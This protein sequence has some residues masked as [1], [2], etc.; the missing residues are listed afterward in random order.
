MSKTIDKEPKSSEDKKH[1][2][3]WLE[4]GAWK[5][6]TTVENG[7]DRVGDRYNFQTQQVV[8]AE[9]SCGKT[10]TNGNDAWKHIEEVKDRQT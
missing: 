6:Q 4:A 7:K 2:I 8:E 3:T 9:C 10:F 1:T 5:R